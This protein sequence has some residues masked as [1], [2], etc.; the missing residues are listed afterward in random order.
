MDTAVP[1][2]RESV[3]QDLREMNE[4]A[5]RTHA[6]DGTEI[7]RRCPHGDVVVL[8]EFCGRYGRAVARFREEFERLGGDGP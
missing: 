3:P 2:V 4:D 5:D 8:A 7:V 1:E 6:T